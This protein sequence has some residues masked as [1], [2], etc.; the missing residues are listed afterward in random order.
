MCHNLL[1]HFRQELEMRLL[2]SKEQIVLG[3]KALVQNKLPLPF[4]ELERQLSTLQK[5][6]ELVTFVVL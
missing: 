3:F 5:E 2:Q 1:F 4:A 6:I